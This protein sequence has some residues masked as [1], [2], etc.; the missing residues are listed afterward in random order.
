MKI[1]CNLSTELMELLDEK[2]VSVDFVKIV[3]SKSNEEIPQSYKNYGTLLLH[4]VGTDVPQHTGA[5]QL[6]DI[7]WSMIREKTSFC[8]SSFIGLH[9][10]TYKSDWVEQEVTCEMVKERM[11]NFIRTWKKQLNLDLLIENVP[12]THYYESNNPG[13]MKHSVSPKLISDLCREHEIGLLLDLAHA[14]IAASGLNIPLNDYLLALPLELVREIHV[15]GTRNTEDGLR[16]NH[17]EMEDEDYEI[18]EFAL[19]MTKPEI[20]TL[21]Y[22]GFGEHFSWRSDK[23]AIERQLKRIAELI[24]K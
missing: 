23:A 16:D 6:D 12:Y 3:L 8:E 21:E 22:G 14:K 13:F 5:S 24:N 18:L 10:V 7:D 1:G 11:S 2:R 19:K 17:L 20:V 9:C 15:V 4:G